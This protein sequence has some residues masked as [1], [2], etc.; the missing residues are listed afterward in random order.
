MPAKRYY[1]DVVINFALRIPKDLYT[2]IKELAETEQRS[3]NAQ[4][5]YI[6]MQYL[7]QKKK[8]KQD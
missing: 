1:N 7:D 6:L 8:E 2:A 5:I 3:I 4:I